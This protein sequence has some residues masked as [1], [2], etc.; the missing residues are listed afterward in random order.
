MQAEAVPEHVLAVGSGVHECEERGQRHLQA[1]L[2]PAGQA[3][4]WQVRRERA[5]VAFVV[6]AREPVQHPRPEPRVERPVDPGIPGLGADNSQFA[7]AV[8]PS[9]RR[10]RRHGRGVT[11]ARERGRGDGTAPWSWP[12]PVRRG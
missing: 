12:T 10:R 5:A 1:Q 2:E 4:E 7:A 9:P 6:V 8:R 11:E 3:E